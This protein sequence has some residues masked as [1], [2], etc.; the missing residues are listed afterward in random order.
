MRRTTSDVPQRAAVATGPS[1]YDALSGD[2]VPVTISPV[3]A[4]DRGAL[5]TLVTGLSPAAHR[6]AQ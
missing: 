3:T 4:A 6:R 2:G 5:L 1:G